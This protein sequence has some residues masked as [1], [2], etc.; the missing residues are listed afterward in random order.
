MYNKK[1]TATSGD[2]S[3]FPPGLDILAQPAAAAAAASGEKPS[4]SSETS[5][6]EVPAISGTK[7][8]GAIAISGVE[9]EVPAQKPTQL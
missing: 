2:K 3:A 9:G 5:K 7:A 4:T 1:L 6:E 8:E